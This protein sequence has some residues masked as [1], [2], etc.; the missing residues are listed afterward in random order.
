LHN[1]LVSRTPRTPRT[2]SRKRPLIRVDANSIE[3]DDDADDKEDE[4]LEPEA[5]AEAEAG[6]ENR[7]SYCEDSRWLTLMLGVDL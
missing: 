6:G 2:A 4:E 5:A 7:C 3:D 1:T